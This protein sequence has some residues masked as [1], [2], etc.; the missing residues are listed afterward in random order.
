MLAS[1]LTQLVEGEKAALARQKW[2]NEP[3][4]TPLPVILADFVSADRPVFL[5]FDEVDILWDHQVDDKPVFYALVDTLGTQLGAT[6]SLC[7]FSGRR[8][9]LFRVGL[10]VNAGAHA[11][12]RPNRSSFS[13]PR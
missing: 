13:S 10:H 5:H 12:L 1:C 7:Y 6:H 2:K 4:T 3:I 8:L 9:E 11:P